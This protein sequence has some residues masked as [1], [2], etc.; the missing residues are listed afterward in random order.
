MYSSVES[1]ES[2]SPFIAGV[3]LALARKDK[4]TKKTLFTFEGPFGLL[5]IYSK[6]KKI[7]WKM[8]VDH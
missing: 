5:R 7:R 2:S 1:C 8:V 3:G 4:K 6:R